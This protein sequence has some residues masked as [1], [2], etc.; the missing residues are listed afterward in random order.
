M[1]LLRGS[2]HSSCGR[3]LSR[4]AR[5][6]AAKCV[7]RRPRLVRNRNTTRTDVAAFPP[8]ALPLPASKSHFITAVSPNQYQT[9]PLWH[10]RIAVH[11]AALREE[12]R[13]SNAA[14]VRTKICKSPTLYSASPPTRTFPDA[15]LWQR[16]ASTCTKT[17][18]EEHEQYGTAPRRGPVGCWPLAD[19]SRRRMTLP[20]RPGRH[21][22]T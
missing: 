22:A 4:K 2:A 8:F 7:G 19:R 13:S 20:G 16:R 15:L 18:L 5:V 3:K 21:I 10:T 17:T 9:S 11:V 1:R 14:T 6:A 12:R